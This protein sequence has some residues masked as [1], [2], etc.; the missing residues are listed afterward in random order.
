[1]LALMCCLWE[2]HF[3]IDQGLGF[4]EVFCCF[5]FLVQQ[6]FLLCKHVY[7]TDLESDASCLTSRIRPRVC[8]RVLP[9]CLV[10]IDPF[11]LATDFLMIIG[12]EDHTF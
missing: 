9:K 7:T 8:F 12:I 5:L 4:I 11:T 6:C 3:S 2:I 1:V 10:D